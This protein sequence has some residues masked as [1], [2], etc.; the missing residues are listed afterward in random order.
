M[1]LVDLSTAMLIPDCNKT[2]LRGG[3]LWKT[4]PL[5]PRGPRDLPKK[6]FCTP[7][8]E[9]L[10]EGEARGPRGAKSLLMQMSEEGFQYIL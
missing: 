5:P 9:M 6:G 2:L 4:R 3:V 1:K 7:R 8:P 10:L